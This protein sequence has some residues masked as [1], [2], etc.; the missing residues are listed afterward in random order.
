MVGIAGTGLL[1]GYSIATSQNTM[2]S[3]FVGK[4]SPRQMVTAWNAI[5]TRG[6][7]V[8]VPTSLLS[9][10]AYFAAAYK[11]SQLPA[12]FTTAL[13]LPQSSQL[14]LA[15]LAVFAVAPFTLAVMMPNI[16]VLQGVLAKME[17]P[18]REEAVTESEKDSVGPRVLEWWHRH[19]VRTA[20]FTAAF[21]LG[22]TTL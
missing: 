7:V 4:L 3:I 6:A 14:A 22:L 21:F 13:G 18:S 20:M 2:P 17:D 9:A 5:Y 15:G 10:S 16:K 1:A 19:N 8:V 11:Q 12:T